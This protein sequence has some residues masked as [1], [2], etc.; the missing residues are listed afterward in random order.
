MDICEAVSSIRNK[1]KINIHGYLMVKDK[2]RN[3]SYYWY[4]KKRDQLRCNGR[5]TTMFTKN[6]YHLVKFT[7]HNHAADASQVK[8]VKSLN[9][10]KEQAQQT[11]DQLV[12]VIQSVLAGSS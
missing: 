1:N 8:V 12:Q 10:L 9:L 3:N 4:C 11:N 2:K 5:A 6:Q 7:D